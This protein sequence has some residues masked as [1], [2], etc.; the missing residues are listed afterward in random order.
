MHN[1][2]TGNNFRHFAFYWSRMIEFQG[3]FWGENYC[4]RLNHEFKIILHF[5]FLLAKKVAKIIINDCTQYSLVR[6]FLARKYSW[7]ISLCL[8]SCHVDVRFFSLP[9]IS[10]LLRPIVLHEWPSRRVSSSTQ[11]WLSPR[12][13]VA[14]VYIGNVAI[15]TFLLKAVLM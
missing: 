9:P 1:T 5:I 15:S 7:R 6:I 2:V 4:T 13:K 12:R 11:K 14:W 10:S 8:Q 3:R